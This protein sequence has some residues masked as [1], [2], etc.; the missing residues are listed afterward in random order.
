MKKNMGIIDKTIRILVAIVFVIL[1]FTNVVSG[2][3]GIIFLII[4]GIFLITSIIGNCPLY[5][6]FGIKTTKFEKID[7]KSV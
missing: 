4:A 7:I 6:P 5:T 2:V 3:L 1:F